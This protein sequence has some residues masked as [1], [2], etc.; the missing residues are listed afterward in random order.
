MDF[1]KRA[2]S[3]K[4][5][6]HTLKQLQETFGIPSQTYYQWV[7][8][9]A[10]GHYERKTKQVRSRKIDRE[11]LKKAVENNPDAFLRDLAKPFGCTAHAVF[12]MLKKMKI[13]R[14]KRSFYTLKGPRKKETNI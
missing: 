13:T 9:L 12:Y 3:Y 10:N 6:G 11:Q 14:K 1:I 5:K 4:Q 2:V 7:K 8:K